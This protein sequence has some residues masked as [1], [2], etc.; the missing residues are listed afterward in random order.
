MDNNIINKMKLIAI[1]GFDDDKERNECYEIGFDA[2]LP[3]PF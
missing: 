3:K 2:F 1:S